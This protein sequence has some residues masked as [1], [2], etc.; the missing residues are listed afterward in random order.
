[1]MENQ[2]GTA[3]SPILSILKKRELV[4]IL[5]IVTRYFGGVLLGTGGLV[6]AY[7]EAGTLAIENGEIVKKENGY[8]AEITLEYNMQG[9][10]EYICEKNNINIIAKE[11]TEK[12]KY[13]IEISEEKYTNKSLN[14]FQ[15]IPIILKGNKYINKD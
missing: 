11:F 2:H 6:K 14:V 1:M 12:I 10:F 4:N 3:G 7:S 15:K 8:I 5:V 9:D 13:L